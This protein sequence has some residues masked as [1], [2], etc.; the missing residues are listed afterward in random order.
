MNR[1]ERRRK[2]RKQGKDLKKLK[3]ATFAKNTDGKVFIT[4]KIKEWSY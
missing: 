4:V 3:G 2:E 1:S